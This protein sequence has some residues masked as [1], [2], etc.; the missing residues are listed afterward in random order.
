MRSFVLPP[1]CWQG[2]AG[3]FWELWPAKGHASRTLAAQAARAGRAG[4]RRQ[5]VHT[6]R[7]RKGAQSRPL[8][9]YFGPFRKP[10][11]LPCPKLDARALSR[12]A[13]PRCDER[14]DAQATNSGMDAL[15][16]PSVPKESGSV[17][18]SGSEGLHLMRSAGSASETTPEAELAQL[19]ARIRELAPGLS[20]AALGAAGS[21]LAEL[22]A[23]RVS[24][25]SPAQPRVLAFGQDD[26][27]PPDACSEVGSFGSLEGEEAA[28]DR[29]SDD[30]AEALEQQQGRVKAGRPSEERMGG[31][32]APPRTPIHPLTPHTP[33]P[34]PPPHTCTHAHMHY[35][36]GYHRPQPL[37]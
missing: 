5:S 28:D 34:T 32:L 20:P 4:A 19:L 10:P 35:S 25:H 15:G 18:I 16:T 2:W 31:A 8:K 30:E 36:P 33:S 37:A 26:G 11:F 7:D 12:D 22:A 17:P 14:V 24:G 1:S 23:S 13:R 3:P 9:A 21:D 29:D 6:L 27:R